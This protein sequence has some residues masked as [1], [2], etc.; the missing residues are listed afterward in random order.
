[1][2]QLKCNVHTCASNADDCCYRPEIKVEGHDACDC[3][4]TCCCSFQEKEAAAGNLL[5]HDVP[6][7][8]LQVSCSV[9][10]CVYN[11]QGQCHAE[12]ID[13]SGDSA[14]RESETECATF[15]KR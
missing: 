1:M 2:T 3:G 5:R 7:N 9:Q 8:A 4:D 14:C 15:Q 12:A 13:V 10:S 11:G 6:N